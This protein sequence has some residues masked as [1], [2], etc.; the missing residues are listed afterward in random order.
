MIFGIVGRDACKTAPAV[1]LPDAND[2]CNYVY[3]DKDIHIRQRS[4]KTDF[5]R[6]EKLPVVSGDLACFVDGIIYNYE[7]LKQVLEKKGH[8]FETGGKF[9]VVIHL[10]KVFGNDFLGMLKG[11]YSVALWDSKS[12]KLMI[13]CDQE[14]L[15][16]VYYCYYDN[17]LVFSSSI[18]SILKLPGIVPRVNW[19]EVYNH[20][21]DPEIF[22]RDTLFKGIH[23]LNSGEALLI[24]SRR[25][26]ILNYSYL[27]QGIKH[28]TKDFRK[29]HEQALRHAVYECLS[30]DRKTG[31][32]L[33]GGVDSAA[34]LYFAKQHNRDI[35]CYSIGFDE[36]SKKDDLFHSRALAEKCDVP[37]FCKALDS[38]LICGMDKYMEI[39]HFTT[40]LDSVIPTYETIKLGKKANVLL[41][42]A[43]SE[44][45][46]GFNL[47]DKLMFAV[48]IASALLRPA[49][50][51]WMSLK[52][53]RQKKELARNRRIA[54]L[55]SRDKFSIKVSM[56]RGFGEAEKREI[57]GSKNIVC[58]DEYVRKAYVRYPEDFEEQTFYR[59]KVYLK[60]RT[61]AMHTL[62]EVSYPFLSQEFRALLQNRSIFDKDLLDPKAPLKRLV[63]S[64]LSKDA[65]FR[66]KEN[67]LLPFSFCAEQKDFL[68]SKIDQLKCRKEFS[69]SGIEKAVGQRDAPYYWRKVSLLASL[70]S[71]LGVYIDGKDA[72]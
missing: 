67:F 3:S 44:C 60:N 24:S 43:G 8:R 51:S 64:R 52:S 11:R 30:E 45:A 22:Y 71:W 35:P 36:D 56:L 38:S 32:M 4:R 63:A 1:N 53:D 34:M 16:P 40:S 7:E 68:Y 42:G 66:K 58:T 41:N 55:T 69:R 72:N 23:K 29:E 39:D 33:S 54:A 17:S 26:T 14:G 6:G 59:N 31:I 57:F 70:E 62:Q 20:M 5:L 2:A 50:T 47:N 27:R 15:N 13:C 25:H 12:R 19:Q 37:Y 49:I 46:Y 18:H 65:A 9:E 61:C 48:P 10:Y 21:S 28:G